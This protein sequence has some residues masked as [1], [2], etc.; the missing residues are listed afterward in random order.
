MHRKRVAMSTP[1]LIVVIINGP[2]GKAKPVSNAPVG[3]RPPPAKVPYNLADPSLR[4]PF[5]Y[6]CD[7]DDA[8]EKVSSVIT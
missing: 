1:R 5:I 7:P 2:A 6:G 3:L 8:F 4:F